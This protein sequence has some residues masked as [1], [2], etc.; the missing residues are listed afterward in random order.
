VVLDSRFVVEAVAA[1][2]PCRAE[3]QPLLASAS[4]MVSE[5][6]D[7]CGARA[8]QEACLSWPLAGAGCEDRTRH[9][10]ITNQ[11]LYQLS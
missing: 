7:G 11:V 8:V 5:G 6:D 1:V 3:A 9:L 10:M 4:E 2:G